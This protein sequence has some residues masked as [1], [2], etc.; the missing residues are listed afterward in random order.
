MYK[1]MI[2]SCTLG[3]IGIRSISVNY[4][5]RIKEACIWVGEGRG[6]GSECA[7]SNKLCTGV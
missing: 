3:V 4:F 7:V 1:T 2:F 5:Q 6:Q